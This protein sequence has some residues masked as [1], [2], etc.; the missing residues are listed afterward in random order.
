MVRIDVEY[1][2]N[3]HTRSVHEPS[4]SELETDAPKDNEGLGAAYSPT[5]LVATELATCMLTTM[6]IVA[7]RHAWPLEGARASVEKHMTTDPVRRI[8]R[9]VVSLRM[10][11]G[12]PEDARGVLE[13]TAHT[14]PVERSLHPDVELDVRFDWG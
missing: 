14:C 4:G 12:I 1:T 6:G 3:L 9:L 11:A 2:G 5:D 13:R 10:P 8:G 7:R